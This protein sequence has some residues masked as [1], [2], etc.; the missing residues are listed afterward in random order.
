MTE[1]RSGRKGRKAKKNRPGQKP[2][3]KLNQWIEDRMKG[4]IMEYREQVEAGQAPQLRMIA[5]AWNVSKN[6]LQR[7]VKNNLQGYKHASGHKPVL[8]YESEAELVRLIKT[9]SK[10]GFPLRR[11]EIQSLAY[12][13]A[14]ANNLPGFFFKREEGWAVLVRKLFAPKS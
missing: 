1:Q 5:R 7:R 14:E 12:Q 3:Q 8:P 10:R 13:Y 2:G 11:K 4:A 9:L 6:T